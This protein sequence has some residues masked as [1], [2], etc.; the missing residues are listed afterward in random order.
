MYTDYV[1]KAGFLLI[2]LTKP[3]LQDKQLMIKVGS[4]KGRQVVC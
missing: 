3:K 4:I 2:S 1:G